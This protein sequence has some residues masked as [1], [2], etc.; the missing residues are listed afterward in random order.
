MT[1][2]RFRPVSACAPSR[3]RSLARQDYEQLAPRFMA[4]PSFEYV[5]GGSGAG[6]TAAA[7]RA[8]FARWAILPRILPT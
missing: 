4:L 6:V 1:H 7:N 2:T 3:R 5:A 8:A